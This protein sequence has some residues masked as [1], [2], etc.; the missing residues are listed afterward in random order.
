MTSETPIRVKTTT[1]TN[2]RGWKWTLAQPLAAT[3]HFAVIPNTWAAAPRSCRYSLTHRPTGL[4][5]CY[6]HNKDRLLKAAEA[7]E[8]LPVQWSLTRRSRLQSA[9]KL[10][11]PIL[12]ACR[13]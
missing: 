7:L 4:A 10:A 8:H 13:G 3:A 9:C 2:K 11:S 12:E 5:V 6:G 1:F